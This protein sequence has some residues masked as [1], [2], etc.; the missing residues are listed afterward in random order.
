MSAAPTLTRR[1]KFCNLDATIAIARITPAQNPRGASSKSVAGS[2][3]GKFFPSEVIATLG[4]FELEV[5]WKTLPQVNHG[6]QRTLQANW[7]M[8]SLPFACK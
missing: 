5:P 4:F 2:E 8:G 7:T 3:A 6:N 1:P